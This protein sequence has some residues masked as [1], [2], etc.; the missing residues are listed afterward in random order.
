M[1]LNGKKVGDDLLTPGWT[2]YRKTCPYNT[3]DVTDVITSGENAMGVMLGN[4]MFNVPRTPGATP[5]S[6]ARWKR[7][8]IAQLD[9]VYA[10]GTAETVGTDQTW[11][12]AK[13]PITFSNVYG[14]EDYDARLEQ[15]GLAIVRAS[16]TLSGN[17]LSNPTDL[18]V[19][20]A[21]SVVLRHRF[22][23]TRNSVR[24]K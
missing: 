2:N 17:Q 1:S 14:G 3:Y 11:R 12:I 16:T 8:I 6:Q 13:S 5:N 9:I 24:L 15:S 4:G 10:D 20:Y 23:S 21:A 19:N 22:A 18:A 7:N